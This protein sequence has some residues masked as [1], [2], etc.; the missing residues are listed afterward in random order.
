MPKAVH[1]TQ[2]YKDLLQAIKDKNLHIQ[3]ARADITIQPADDVTMEFFAPTRDSYNDLNDYS[4]VLKITYGDIAYLF[5]GDVTSNVEAELEGD[6]SADVL[7]VGHSRLYNHDINVL[8]TDELGTVEI[9]TDGES[10]TVHTRGKP[11]KTNAPPLLS[12]TPDVTAPSETKT[13]VS[14]TMTAKPH[15]TNPSAANQHVEQ[16]P[17]P[18]AT[19][20]PTEIKQTPASTN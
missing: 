1:T 14:P 3:T 4:V 15:I 17:T 18:L 2:I 9:D 5:T 7:K 16:V 8:R 11:P 19:P 13:A 20:V 6:L 12:S 10:L